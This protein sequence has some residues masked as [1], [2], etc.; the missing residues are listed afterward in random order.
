MPL[1]SVSIA[2]AALQDQC[3]AVDEAQ[4]VL[5][6][7]RAI[8]DNLIRDAI[9][10]HVPAKRLIKSTG[11]S[12]DRIYTIGQQ[13]MVDPDTLQPVITDPTEE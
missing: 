11:L 1:I 13:P 7:E 12:R 4:A 9:D 2:L 8:R 3:T 10:S 5:A 6:R